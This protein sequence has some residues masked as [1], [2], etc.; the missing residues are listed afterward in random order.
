VP[1]PYIEPWLLEGLS[2][3]KL[4]FAIVQDYD[5]NEL[6]KEISAAGFRATRIA[7]TGGFLRVGNTTLM[8]GVE[9][10]QVRKVIRLIDQYCRQ[11]TETVQP[12]VIGDFHEWYP[13]EMV[14]VVV[15]GATIFVV[16]VVRFERI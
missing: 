4:I 15:G 12:E 8:I 7:S 6:V 9:D 3:M 14:D 1:L 5:A 13:A 2:T 11:R 10:Y 16:N